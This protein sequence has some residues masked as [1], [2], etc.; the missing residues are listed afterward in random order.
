M[1]YAA[2]LVG[3]LLIAF[4]IAPIA[5]GLLV[6]QMLAPIFGTRR[7]FNI[8]FPQLYSVDEAAITNAALVLGGEGY[9]GNC[10]RWYITEFDEG[11]D[12]ATR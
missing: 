11:A 1:H 8:P 2:P 6:E 10:D 3:V 4:Y 7:L 5:A 9:V 12:D